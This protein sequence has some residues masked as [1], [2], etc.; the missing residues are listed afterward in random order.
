MAGIF[1][2]VRFRLTLWYTFTLVV[3]L[4]LYAGIS[5][6]LVFFNLRNNIDTQLE[7][8]YEVVEGMFEYGPGDSLHF[9]AD[10]ETFLNER[11]VEILTADGKPFFNSRPFSGQSLPPLLPRQIQSATMR[12]KTISLNNGAHVRVM[13]TKANIGGQQYILR[14]IRP[15]EPVHNELHKFFFL[16]L[17]ALP[18]A[19]LIAGAG[20][21]LLAGKLLAPVGK[22]TEK[23]RRISSDKLEERLPVINPEDELGQLAITMNDLLDRLQNAFER[24]RQFTYD[25]AHELRTPLTSIRSIGEV[26]LQETDNKTNYREVIGSILEENN[27]L[28]QLVNSLLF[29]SR[30]DAQ[31]YQ[32]KPEQVTVSGLVRQ[33]IEMIQPLAEEKN[34][35]ICFDDN[36]EITIKADPTLLRQALL[37]L[38]DNAI[39][40]APADTAITVTIRTTKDKIIIRIHDQGEKIPVSLKEKIFERFFRIDE[41]RSKKTDGSGL[42]LAIARWAVEVQ[43]G[44]LYLDESSETG[45]TFVINLSH[46]T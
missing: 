22:M 25:A 41:S 34:Q 23:A 7:H 15:L 26:A 27:R 2:H 32:V 14:M 16:L 31:T 33:T 28:T 1:S 29:L 17:I 6:M 4:L 8:D 13:I 30:T 21:Y 42:G 12:Y 43:G 46:I 5:I 44:S 9:D 39:K 37:N 35:T 10:D 19:I 3:I 40:Y 45:N 11:W 18:V 20:G 38:L 36:A 24:L